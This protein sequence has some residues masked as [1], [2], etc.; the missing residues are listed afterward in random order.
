MLLVRVL[1]PVE[2]GIEATELPMI[3]PEVD[4]EL[5]GNGGKVEFE[6]IET[7]DAPE[8]Y[9]GEVPVGMI[10]LDFVE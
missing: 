1:E 3:P 9:T 7:I 8:E 5:V 2:G 4:V 10:E 6:G